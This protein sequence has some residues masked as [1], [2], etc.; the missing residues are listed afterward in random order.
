MSTDI[1][2][3]VANVEARTVKFEKGMK[4]VSDSAQR[5]SH[6]TRI[7][8]IAVG[9]II[10]KTAAGAVKS[11]TSMAR[12]IF[13]TI[14]NTAALARNIG[15]G[16]T[17]LEGLRHAADQMTTIGAEGLTSVLERLTRRVGLAVDGMGAAS[18]ALE[19]LGLDARELANMSPDEQFRRIADR[20]A[21]LPTHA[22]RAGVAFQIFGREGSKMVDMLSAG[23]AG[24]DAFTRDITLLQGEL[25]MLDASKVEAMDGAINRMQKA[26]VGG[27]RQLAILVAPAVETV[28]NLV[29][30]GF[31]NMRQLVER[32]LDRIR[33]ISE[34][35]WGWF[36]NRGVPILHSWW[37]YVKALFS[38][39][40]SFTSTVFGSIR[41]VLASTIGRFVD[42]SGSV[43][44]WL[45]GYQRALITARFVIENWR[46]YT[47][48]ALLTAALGV[49]KF[50]AEVA[51]TFSERIPSV[52]IW[53]RDNWRDIFTDLTTLAWTR[54]KN[55]VS[56]VVNIV[57]SIPDLISGRVSFD[58]LWT[59]LN[60]GFVATLSELPNIAERHKGP[61]ERVLESQIASIHQG[62][63]GSL[64]G[65]IEQELERSKETSKGF[66]DWIGSIGLSLPDVARDQL[67]RSDLEDFE[68][69]LL[70]IGNAA[71]N[72]AQQMK[73]LGD[74]AEID[75]ARAGIG[76][77]PTILGSGTTAETAEAST[78]FAGRT[79]TI[80]KSAGGA[81]TP[82]QVAKAIQLLEDIL[83]AQRR[84]A[85]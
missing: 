44:T 82:T 52:L 6:S 31:I 57:T 33:V 30:L 45:D 39:A 66:G 34:R 20:I 65:F 54:I 72:A 27:F 10:A 64:S 77:A 14:N 56:N 46:R 3:L 69:G 7:S 42:F 1:G 84:V 4:N 58:E 5:M 76:L 47:D 11:F 37:E 12:S 71:D 23:S 38:L 49:V 41:A 22:E 2:T 62:L 50:G 60:E 78:P 16:I 13:S 51:H 21:A 40:A 43:D 9:N 48:L 29:T 26:A 8:L 28:A 73:K 67:D 36:L 18:G 80:H 70:D 32:S 55:F 15:I 61:F 25:T 85:S 53:L 81:W 83:T 63:S 74:S 19:Q 79:S 17:E 59:P 75:I 35:T 68:D 24:I